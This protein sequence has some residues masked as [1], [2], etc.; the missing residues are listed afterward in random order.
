MDSI[1]N[2]TVRRYGPIKVN[3]F[4]EDDDE[5]VARTSLCTILRNYI[6]VQI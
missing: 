5:A 1:K 3:S 6:K 2:H 4:H